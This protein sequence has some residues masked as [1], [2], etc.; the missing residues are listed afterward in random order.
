MTSTFK[1]GLTVLFYK[2]PLKTLFKFDEEE[3]NNRPQGF[4]QSDH[5]EGCELVIM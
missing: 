5:V 3:N 2:R 1:K 4:P